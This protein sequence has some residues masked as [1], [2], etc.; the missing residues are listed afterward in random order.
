MNSIMQ[1]HTQTTMI[2]TVAPSDKT[3][4]VRLASLLLF[5][6]M[7]LQG[8]PI[9]ASEIT[10]MPKPTKQEMFNIIDQLM[11]NLEFTVS[12]IENKFCPEGL[13]KT[14]HSNA[15]YNMY[16]CKCTTSHWLKSLDLRLPVNTTNSSKRF[17]A[18]TVNGTGIKYDDIIKQYGTIDD[19][20]APGPSQPPETPMYLSYLLDW[21]KLSFGINKD[22]EQ[23]LTEIIFNVE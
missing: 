6:T 9:F 8:Q 2:N 23:N 17:L 4:Q 12:D 18:L 22:K 14:Q 11:G 1:K 20:S 21:G 19:L 10:T 5:F 7:L 3:K 13:K 16:E 15:F